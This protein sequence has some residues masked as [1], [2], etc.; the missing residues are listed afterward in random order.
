VSAAE[1]LKPD[2]LAISV[3]PALGGGTAPIKT[4]PVSAVRLEPLAEA[5]PCNEVRGSEASA[6]DAGLADE[7]A[8]TLWRDGGRTW[9]VFASPLLSD[10]DGC[11]A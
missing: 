5:G 2:R 8:D 3:R 7:H 10:H 1:R 6:V 4:W 11:P 9:Q